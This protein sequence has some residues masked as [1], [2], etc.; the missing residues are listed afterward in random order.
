MRI[1]FD[2]PSTEVRTAFLKILV[3]LAHISLLDG[4]CVPP[5]LN[6]PTILLD[7]TATL[8]DHLLHAVLSLLHREISDHGRHLPH[9]FSLFHTYASLGLAEKAQ[10]LKL[11]VPVTFMLV[12]IDE[13]PGPTIKYQYPELTKLHQVVSMLI[14]CCDV[15]SKAHSSLAQS[16]VAP[17]PN[18]YGDPACQNEYL[19]PIQPQ[20]ADILFVKNSYMKKLIEDADVNVTED[21]VKLLQYCC[22]EN[23][24]VSRTVLSELLWQIGFSFAHE[25][26]HHTDLL[27]AVL[28]MEGLVANSSCS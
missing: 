28:L 24:H 17:L 7:P 14:R 3:F 26:K 23:P 15:S 18:P 4:P 10:L 8:S 13:G 6:A 5:S 25:I 12:A 16:G 21:T 20:A 19:M 2:C 9:Y 22:W 27:L 11:N 1:S